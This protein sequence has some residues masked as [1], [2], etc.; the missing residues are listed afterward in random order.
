MASKTLTLLKSKG[1]LACLKYRLA[2]S[3]LGNLAFSFAFWRKIPIPQDF[4]FLFL[5]THRA[6]HNAM[7]RFLKKSNIS[8]NVHFL[9]NGAKRYTNELRLLSSYPTYPICMLSEWNFEGYEKYTSLLQPAKIP[10]LILVRD[11]IS[12][13]KSMVNFVHHRTDGYQVMGGGAEN[14][15][16]RI[17]I[18]HLF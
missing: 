14:A 7:I 13:C 6:G 8:F 12:I 15:L 11:P 9:E 18:L 1:I 2:K 4:R 10:A 5:T 16:C 3:S 17:K